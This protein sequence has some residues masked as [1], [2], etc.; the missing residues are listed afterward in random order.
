MEF[1]QVVLGHCLLQRLLVFSIRV[2]W[3]QLAI[4]TTLFS[5]TPCRRDKQHSHNYTQPTTFTSILVNSSYFC[6]P[7]LGPGMIQS[8]SSVSLSSSIPT[9]INP[10]IAH[11]DTTIFTPIALSPCSYLHLRRTWVTKFQAWLNCCLVVSSGEISFC[12]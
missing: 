9:S 4:P 8:I 10:G 3:K 12:G 1:A 6:L 7:F 5:D 11:S 2:L